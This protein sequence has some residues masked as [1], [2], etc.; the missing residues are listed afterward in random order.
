MG[1]QDPS[2]AVS[3]GSAATILC[4]HLFKN[5]RST[6]SPFPGIAG[7]G[8]CEHVSVGHARD[9]SRGWGITHPDQVLSCAKPSALT[10]HQMLARAL[11]EEGARSASVGLGRAAPQ[12]APYPWPPAKGLSYRTRQE[13]HFLKLAPPLPPKL[14]TTSS[15]PHSKRMGH[16]ERCL[17]A[18][19]EA[20]K[21]P[22]Y[23]QDRK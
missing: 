15:L 16:Q 11:L 14:P 19:R 18:G 7:D 1:C 21:K 2:R 9:S 8:A 17:E 12:G 6:F 13:R 5:K 3:W 23:K 20:V 4:L 10:P 22:E